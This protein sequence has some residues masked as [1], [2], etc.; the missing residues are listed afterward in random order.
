MWKPVDLIS[1]EA[2]LKCLIP[3]K[4]VHIYWK[5]PKIYMKISFEVKALKNSQIITCSE[6]PKLL[7][8]FSVSLVFKY[9]TLAG[10][11][12]WIECWPED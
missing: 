3:F 11:A 7:F 10:M 2:L 1:S 9:W 8:M 5:T 6:R 4:N 12:Q